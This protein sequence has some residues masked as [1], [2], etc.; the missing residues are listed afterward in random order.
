MLKKRE[1]TFSDDVLAF[2]DVV[3]LPIV[4]SSAYFAFGSQDHDSMNLF[5]ISCCATSRNEVVL[6]PLR[7][8]RY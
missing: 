1:V 4:V 6:P 2:V 8:K 7:A 3:F 5:I